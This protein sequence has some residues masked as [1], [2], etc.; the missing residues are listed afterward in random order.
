MK[1]LK[2]E[3]RT[4]YRQKLLLDLGEEKEEIWKKVRSVL[5]SSLDWAPVEWMLNSKWVEKNLG[6]DPG[7]LPK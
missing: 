7:S 5:K 4:L 6:V 1:Q 3:N 2:K